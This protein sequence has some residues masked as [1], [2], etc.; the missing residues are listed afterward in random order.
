MIL[1]WVLFACKDLGT[2]GNFYKAMLG[3]GVPLVDNT[4]LFQLS[5]YA[6]L[7]P[8]LLIG[9]TDLPKRCVGLLRQRIRPALFEKLTYGACILTTWVCVAFLVADSYNPFLYFRF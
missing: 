2:A 9:A 6:L 7:L 8:I 3:I 5:N 4:A 1:G